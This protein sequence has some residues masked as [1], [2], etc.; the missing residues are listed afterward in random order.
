[1]II[2]IVKTRVKI[3]FEIFNSFLSVDQG[4]IVGRSMARVMQLAAMKTRMMKS[5]QSWEVSLLQIFL[6]LESSLKIYSEW[7][8]LW[9]KYSLIS[10]LKDFS[11]MSP[12][13]WHHDRIFSTKPFF[14][15]FFSTEEIFCSPSWEKSLDGFL[16]WTVVML[17]LLYRLEQFGLEKY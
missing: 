14:L 5:N 2:S 10:S 11:V 8:C 7:D 1:M 15:F 4:G 13:L 16:L 9:M 12:W 17:A 3:L 6:V